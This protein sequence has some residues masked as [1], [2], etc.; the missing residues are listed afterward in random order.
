MSRE[1]ER[2][3]GLS[4]VIAISVGAMVGSGIFILPALALKLAGP[5]VILAYFLAALVVLPA[6]LSKAEMAT[7]MPESGGAYVY[8][9]RSMGPMLGTIAGVGTWFSLTFKGALALVGGAPYIILLLDLPVLPVAVGL[10]FVLTVINMLGAK[11]T[12]RMQ[13][14]MVVLMLAAMAWF[15]AGST[16]AVEAA[17]FDNFGEKGAGG[18][19]A[20]TGFVFVSYAG[21]T[22]IS[23]VAEEIENPSRNIPIG[24]L[25]SLGFTTVLY[26]MVVFVLV[27]VSPS[28]D[29][30]GSVTPI[31]DVAEVTLAQTGVIVVVIAAILAL[32]S[33]ANA[34]LLSSSRYPFAMSRDK[35]A[36]P[37]LAYVSERFETPTPAIALTGGLTVLLIV[38]VPIM[39]IAKLGSAFKIL[40]FVLINVALIAFR[41]SDAKDYD[42]DF[43]DPLYP[44]SQAFGIIGGLVLLT[45]MGWIPTLGALAII[46]TSIMWY[47]A[48]ARPRVQREGVARK[49]MRRR[50]G[51]RAAER[52]RDQLKTSDGFDVLVATTEETSP[53]RE[54]AL[55]EIGVRAASRHDGELHVVRF[56]EVPDQLSLTQA[57][58]FQSEDDFAFE[59]RMREFASLLDIPIEVD[60]VVSHDLRHS[61]VNYAEHNGADLLIVG[62]DTSDLRTRLLGSDTDWMLE[63]IPCDMLIADVDELPSGGDV[64]LI[65]DQEPYEPIKIELADALATSMRARL[66]LVQGI[67][68]EGALEQRS[69]IEEYHQDLAQLCDNP[70]ESRIVENQNPA[71]LARAAEGAGWV[72]VQLHSPGMS[73]RKR[74]ELFD[75]LDGPTVVVRPKRS[76]HP[77]LLERIYK[78]F[79]F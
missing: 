30:V 49:E 55:A 74:R 12:G 35:L 37:Q 20:A 69:A 61:I 19:L 72:I 59:E 32:I 48:Y 22:K 5:A 29:L 65:T 60:E 52:T 76:D 57:T 68:P 15:V 4:S 18:I 70:V 28:L 14:I 10:A 66:L 13:V 50:A 73:D 38:G 45:Q 6:A 21:V 71:D 27:G 7:A 51:S 31:A 42:P 79:A 8:I 16:S 36:P 33:T 75:A 43:T 62:A 41:Q 9:E 44:F 77:G 56:D 23:S 11:Q 47:L 58:T 26:I 64:A 40:V 53:D 3:L 24:M 78:R 25:A 54:S 17:A 1:L 67:D 39:E 34:G 2:D 63:H 46:G